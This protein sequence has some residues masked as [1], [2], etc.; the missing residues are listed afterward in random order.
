M[1]AFLL[2]SFLLSTEL[3]IAASNPPAPSCSISDCYHKPQTADK[4]EYCQDAKRDTSNVPLVIQLQQPTDQ[5]CI[6]TE[7]KH[8]STWYRSADWWMVIFSGCLFIA[9]TGLWIYTALMWRTT[10][11]AVKDSA[12]GVD[13]AN[14]TYIATHRP[15]IVV[16]GLF[17]VSPNPS[18]PNMARLSFL[19]TNTGDTDAEIVEF[20]F[21]LIFTGDDS[22]EMPIVRTE[23]A[24]EPPFKL[25]VGDEFRWYGNCEMNPAKVINATNRAIHD[26]EA[27]SE[28]DF[29]GTISFKDLGGNL[30]QTSFHRSY[31]FKK[32]RFNRIENSEFEY[33]G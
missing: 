6:A 18:S 31:D 28:L 33:Q 16:R 19:I 11:T 25:I 24:K 29:R 4:H 20:K 9:T 23:E 5:R 12:K 17:M 2:M 10:R 21:F 15:K 13:L 1:R 8:E 7:P 22:I 30:R 32:R 3:T 27:L 26:Q 14:K